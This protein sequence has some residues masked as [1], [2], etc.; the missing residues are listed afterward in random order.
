MVVSHWFV[1]PDTAGPISGGTLFNRELLRSLGEHSF[2]ARELSVAGALARLRQGEEGFYWVDSLHIPAFPELHR[3]NGGR[4][5]L[6][7]LAHY[8]PSLVSGS[9]S[10]EERFAIEQAAAFISPSEFLRAVLCER[11]ADARPILV[12]EPGRW[13]SGVVAAPAPPG[14]RAV[15]VANLLPS[16]G[17]FELLRALS[18]ELTASD[19]FELTIAGSEEAEPEYARACRELAASSPELCARVRFAGVLSPE[20]AAE[21]MAA[22]NLVVSASRMESYGMVLTEA[23][24]LG[25]PLLARQGGNVKN[26]V[27]EPAGGELVADE[28]AL[29]RAC[30]RLA[31]D[32][33]EHE[34]RLELARRHAWS[35]RAWSLAAS[36]FV[37]QLSALEPRL[38]A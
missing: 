36:E 18:S 19:V 33:R 30:A 13:A 28:P 23:R 5:P 32:A 2:P 1:V 29:A 27:L 35:P 24:T 20:G 25:V 21:L 8:L 26:L 11:G 17:V 38:G 37:A 31:R 4:Q 10:A 3:Q 34:R 9:V 16:K 14:V 22:S 6:G 12:V 15:L 7:L